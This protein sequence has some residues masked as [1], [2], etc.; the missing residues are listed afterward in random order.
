[1]SGDTRPDKQPYSGIGSEKRCPSD[2]F[3]GGRGITGVG[4]EDQDDVTVWPKGVNHE[5]NA[6]A[7]SFSIALRYDSTNSLVSSSPD[8]Y[9]PS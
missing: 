9:G 5:I 7:S 1:M 6:D 3:R 8:V 2:Q 4:D